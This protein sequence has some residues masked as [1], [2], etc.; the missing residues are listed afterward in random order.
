MWL[1][2]CLVCSF[3][4]FF[5]STFSFLF[6][7]VQSHVSSSAMPCHS[8]CARHLVFSP[9]APLLSAL[10]QSALCWRINITAASVES[11]LTFQHRLSRNSVASWLQKH[12]CVKRSG[13]PESAAAG[14]RL[15]LLVLWNL[16]L[17]VWVRPLPAAAGGK[18]SLHWGSSLRTAVVSV[19]VYNQFNL[20][21]TSFHK[22]M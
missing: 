6:L 5:L 7:P 22:R 16:H 21:F 9:F 8:Q 12:G 2:C 14:V 3:L 19:M 10:S 1:N 17:K 11:H 4:L 18:G 20:S 13:G 15:F